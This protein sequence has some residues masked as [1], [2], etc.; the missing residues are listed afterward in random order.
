MNKQK[1]KPRI[2]WLREAGKALL[3]MLVITFALDQ[4]N[5]RDMPD[6]A[7]PSIVTESVAGQKID[8]MA[9]SKEQPVVLYFWATWCGAC[10]FVSPTVNWLPGSYSVVS[11][12]LSSGSDARVQRYL[13]AHEYTFETINDA[14]GGLAKDWGIRV[15]PS[16]VIIKDGK[17]RSITTGI[18]T[19]IGLLARLW[20]A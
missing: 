10:K 9:M 14:Q 11:V 3:L 15:T 8:V 17:I 13:A 1:P 7:I 16:I 2:R 4:W 19:P 18:T 20:L 5:G 6:T 12:A